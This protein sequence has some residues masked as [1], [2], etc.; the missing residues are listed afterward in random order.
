MGGIYSP[1]M[2]TTRAT[3]FGSAAADY[4]RGRP[5]YPAEAIADLVP[6]TAVRVADVGAGTGKLTRALLAP[7]RHVVAVDPD[8]RMLEA[9]SV[10]VPGVETMLGTAESLPFDDE[11]VDAVV[12]GQ[13]WHWTHPED[14]PAEVAR[15]LVPGGRIGLIWNIRDESNPWVAQLTELIGLSA[16]EEMVAAGGPE[17]G[18]RFTPVI[19]HRHPWVRTL[20]VD[21]FVAMIRSRSDFIDASPESWAVTRRALESLAGEWFP[22][23]AIRLP[24]TTHVFVADRL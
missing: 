23:G 17:V 8:P 11:S 5:N 2:T 1:P 9:L 6:S 24:Y 20:T 14:A 4:E 21:E 16:A 22:D 7:G 10:N 19:E 3:N 15:V 18:E 13:A 12:A